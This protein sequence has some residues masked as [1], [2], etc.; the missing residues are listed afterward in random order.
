MTRFVSRRDNLEWA[1]VQQAGPEAVADAGGGTIC[2]D[3][4]DA[5]DTE[6]APYRY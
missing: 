2:V 1:A 4:S 6:P 5:G 3:G